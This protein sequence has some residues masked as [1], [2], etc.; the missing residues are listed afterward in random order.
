[1]FTTIPMNDSKRFVS[2]S[3]VRTKAGFHP[4]S[5]NLALALIA[6]SA[7]VTDDVAALAKHPSAK[8]RRAVERKLVAVT[9]A[10]QTVSAG[11]LRAAKRKAAAVKAAAT[12]KANAA[13]KAING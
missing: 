11:E 12:R 1:M 5:R 7:A 8:V 10:A 4:L 2:R 3:A 9:V 6:A 13:K